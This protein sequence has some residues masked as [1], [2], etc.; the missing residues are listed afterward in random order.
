MGF[1]NGFLYARFEQWSGVRAVRGAGI[2]LMKCNLSI[3][4]WRAPVR[5]CFRND[6]FSD[7]V[8]WD[9]RDKGFQ[10]LPPCLS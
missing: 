5:A 7:A 2:L 1:R 3:Y 4:H 9:E 10:Q 6:R 8:A